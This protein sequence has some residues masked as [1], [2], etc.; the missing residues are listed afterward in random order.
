[1]LHVYITIKKKSIKLIIKYSKFKESKIADHKQKS[2]EL[3]M[4][5]SF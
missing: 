3:T 1:M 2:V 4:I 5:L